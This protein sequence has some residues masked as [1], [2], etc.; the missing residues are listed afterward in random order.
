MPKPSRRTSFEQS[1]LKVDRTVIQAF[2]TFEEAEEADRQY[3]LSRTPVERMIAL[4]HIRQCAWGYDDQ[5]EPGL[6]RSPE[7]LKL[8]RRPLHGDRRVRRELSRVSP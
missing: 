4:E 2:E 7:L 1:L 6:P 5:S 8:R 3:W